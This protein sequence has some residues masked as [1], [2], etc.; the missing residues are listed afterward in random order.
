MEVRVQRH[1]YAQ[2]E[3]TAR[4]LA[5]DKAVII[6]R[7]GRL[8]A[9]PALRPAAFAARDSTTLVIRPASRLHDV[10]LVAKRL[11]FIVKHGT[12]ALPSVPEQSFVP[13]RIF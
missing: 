6:A 8:P 2:Q 11:F 10:I 12:D 1:N 7:L 3:R 9:S 5:L 4:A 13:T